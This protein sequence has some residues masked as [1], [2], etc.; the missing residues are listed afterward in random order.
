MASAVDGLRQGNTEVQIAYIR[1][2]PFSTASQTHAA[3]KL[4]E[5][6]ALTTYS[7]KLRSAYNMQRREG[8]MTRLESISP[9]TAMAQCYASAYILKV[10]GIN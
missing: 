4:D 7:P 8:E 5:V 10:D 2:D 1:V 3:T 9:I 6:I